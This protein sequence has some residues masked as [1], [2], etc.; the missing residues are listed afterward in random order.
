M[1]EMERERREKRLDEDAPL[2]ERSFVSR[3][4]G[5]QAVIVPD[6]G[7]ALAGG[8]RRYPLQSALA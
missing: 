1:L 3:F 2:L 5:Q 6:G 4:G 7:A 8:R